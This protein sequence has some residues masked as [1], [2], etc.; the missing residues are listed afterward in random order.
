MEHSHSHTNEVLASLKNVEST[1]AHSTNT[2]NAPNAPPSGNTT[3]TVSAS[4]AFSPNA[5]NALSY[6][7]QM[8]VPVSASDAFYPN[9]ANALPY[10]G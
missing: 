5:A 8:P 7:G 2:S 4:D 1:L 6:A 9:A 10:T 3:I